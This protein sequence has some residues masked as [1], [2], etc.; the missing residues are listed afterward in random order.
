MDWSAAYPQLTNALSS[1]QLAAL[2]TVVDA[3]QAY[4]KL[5][6]LVGASIGYVVNAAAQ[7]PGSSGR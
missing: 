5:S 3:R 7:K 6:P 1:A 4:V 2:H